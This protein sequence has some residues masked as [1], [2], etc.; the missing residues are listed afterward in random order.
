[1]SKST[2]TTLQT[3]SAD[4]MTLVY[5]HPKSLQFYADDSNTHSQKVT[6][7]NPYDQSV[8]FKI[9]STAPTKYSVSEPTGIIKAK[10]SVDL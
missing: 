8:N 3:N 6:M 7:F 1:M 9:L 5:E 2:M 10:S 4:D